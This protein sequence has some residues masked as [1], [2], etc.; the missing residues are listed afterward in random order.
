MIRV[1]QRPG[2]Q[3]CSGVINEFHGGH[4]RPGPGGASSPDWGIGAHFFE[5]SCSV[6][7]RPQRGRLP[8][9]PRLGPGE[10]PGIP[11]PSRTP[12]NRR[13]H[14]EQR[15]PRERR[16]GAE[17]ARNAG[18]ARRHV[19]Y[20]KAHMW[21]NLAA[22][23]F[24]PGEDRDKAVEDRDHVA[25]RMTPAQISEAEKLAREWRPKK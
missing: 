6:A 10:I 9:V 20:A 25:K 2:V 19:V 21:F 15:D 7:W 12:K 1:R 24:P 3:R 22:S 18:Q 11:G 4:Y 8:G 23:T 16:P 17:R 13:Q 5:F 14:R